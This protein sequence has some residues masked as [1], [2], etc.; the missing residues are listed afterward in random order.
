MWGETGSRASLCTHDF[1]SRTAEIPSCMHGEPKISCRICT[2][3]EVYAWAKREDI[4][5]R[6]CK[7]MR[8][9]LS[10]CECRKVCVKAMCS[11]SRELLRHVLHKR[12]R[13][14][15]AARVKQN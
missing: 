9:A 7:H 4:S 11:D 3:E 8:Q 1:A 5:L 14:A 10:C 2:D 12:C 6:H 15:S 13:A